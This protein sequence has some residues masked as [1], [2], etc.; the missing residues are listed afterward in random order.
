MSKAP[1]SDFTGKDSGT[2][3]QKQWFRRR[4]TTGNSLT[5]PEVLIWLKL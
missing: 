3:V 5:K 2:R 4:P 1:T